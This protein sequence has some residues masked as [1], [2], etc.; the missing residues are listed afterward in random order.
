M[1]REPQCGGRA[2]HDS[3]SGSELT[4]R[5]VWG[6]PQVRPNPLVDGLPAYD[7]RRPRGP[8]DLF[9]DG[10]EGPSPDP[11]VGAALAAADPALWRHY[12]APRR[13][14][15]EI[16]ARFGLPAA[17]VLV[18]AGADD[19]LERALRVAASPGREVILTTPTFEMLARYARLAGADVVEVPWWQ[20]AFPVEK[21]LA[22]VSGRTAAVAVVSPN[23]PTGGVATAGDLEALAAAAPSALLLVDHAYVEFADED[24]TSAALAL[25]NALVFR[26]LSKAWGCAGLRVGWVMGDPRV[27]AWLRAVGQPYAVAAP[28][29]IAGAA[30]LAADPGPR[31][32]FIAEVADERRRLATTLAELSAIPYPSQANFVLARFA[33]APWVRDALAG[34]GIA[35][36]GFPADSVLG[37]CLRLTCPG[38]PAALARLEAALRAALAPEALLLDLDGVLA[39]VSGSYREAIRATAATFGVA[40]TPAD[41]AAGKASGDAANDWRLTQRLL[42]ERGVEV[43]LEEVAARFETLY[44]GTEDEPGLY[45]RERLLPSRDT[46]AA[47]AVRLPLAV[48][49]GRPRADAERFLSDAGVADL[50]TTVVAMEDAPGKPDPAP[51][52]LGLERLGVSRAWMVGDTPDDVRAARAAGVVPLGVVAPGDGDGARDA[53]LAAGAARVLS[54]L[55]QLLEVMP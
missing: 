54:D 47:L 16:A 51:V 44:Q 10:N 25:P 41:I 8:I 36:R 38:D 52:R 11:A 28:S 21:V 46:L 49:T 48:V 9:L 39:D 26:T 7:P 55:E 30:A 29:L 15:A 50:V 22:R 53:L 33:D 13:L 17:A 4:A 12:P 43:P 3:V 32:R 6:E 19:A 31:R 37:P 40:L 35:V 42:A 34:L 20:G 5:Q 2:T 18:T 27:V 24:L 45:T 23:N 14:E 1:K